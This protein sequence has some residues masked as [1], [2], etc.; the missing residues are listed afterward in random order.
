MNENQNFSGKE[1]VIKNGSLKG[2]KIKIEDYW[3]KVAGISWMLAN[4]NPAAMEYAI[5][6]AIDDLPIDNKVFYGKIGGLGMLV[7]E[8]EIN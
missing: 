1:F 8:S 7:H 5:R 4:G 2:Q 3:E 6:G